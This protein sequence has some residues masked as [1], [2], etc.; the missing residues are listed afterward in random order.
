[1][2]VQLKIII[3]HV[4]SRVYVFKCSSFP[5]YLHISIINSRFTHPFYKFFIVTLKNFDSDK[6]Q[7]DKSDYIE[8]FLLCHNFGY[9]YTVFTLCFVATFQRIQLVNNNIINNII[10]EFL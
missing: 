10:L 8:L 1:M 9:I 6:F 3:F 5:V 7:L 2:F 4:V